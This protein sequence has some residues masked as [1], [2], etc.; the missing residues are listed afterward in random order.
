MFEPWPSRS[1]HR[2]WV[3][4]SRK[5]LDRSNGEAIFG[6]DDS[7]WPVRG[8]AAR[9]DSR[10]APRRKALGLRR[11]PIHRMTGRAMRTLVHHQAR[12]FLEQENKIDILERIFGPP[13]EAGASV[14][15]TLPLPS[16]LRP[17]LENA[18]EREGRSLDA[19]I[20]GAIE[21]YLKQQPIAAPPAR[22]GRDGAARYRPSPLSPCAQSGTQPRK[23]PF[24]PVHPQPGLSP[25]TLTR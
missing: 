11:M 9:L 10:F 19:I 18:A 14:P 3:R 22:P 2:M 20:C 21:L 4:P 15:Y 7:R 25:G 8:Q 6:R 13:P 16:A 1:M 12:R 17:L 5:V 23:H 24:D